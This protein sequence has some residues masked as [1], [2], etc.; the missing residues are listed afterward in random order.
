MAQISEKGK[1]RTASATTASGKI[2]VLTIGINDYDAISGFSP[3]TVCANNA[4]AIKNCFTDVFQLGADR[5]ALT[6]LVSNGVLSPSRGEIIKA[7]RKIAMNAQSADRI[8]VYFAGHGLRINDELYLAPQ[9]AY[10]ENDP[11]AHIAFAD[12]C[13]ILENSASK[14][15]LIILDVCLSGPELIGT[16]LLPPKVST[17]YLV[18][19][20]ALLKEVNVFLSS[21]GVDLAN[22]ESPDPKHNIFAYHLI[23]ALKGTAKALNDQ[24]LLTV[25]T[26][27]E[28][29]EAAIGEEVGSSSL[30]RTPSR[31][32][33]PKGMLTIG[34]FSMPLLN[35]AAFQLSEAPLLDVSF[36]DVEKIHVDRILTSL[37]SWSQYS[38]EQIVYSVNKNIGTALS[39]RLGTL[40]AE[41]TEGFGLAEGGVGESVNGII[42]ADGLYCMEYASNEK[43]TGTMTHTV[44]LGPSWFSRPLQMKKLLELFNVRPNTFVFRLSSP[45]KPQEIVPGL[46]SSGWTID[47]KLTE[48]VIASRDKYQ[49]VATP[50]TL[51]FY[52][53]R[54]EDIFGG[55]MAGKSYPTARAVIEILL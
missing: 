37:R 39:A 29:L 19:Q 35:R 13:Q 42:F 11:S 41:L 9:D 32:N 28:Y 25:D 12:L 43:K 51:N 4:A 44:S 7:A 40:I 20:L 47:S 52:G 31:G 27:F 34:D 14:Q 15:S 54:P 17:N 23:K 18:E 55:A 24:K 8:F 22:A 46:R 33:L 16:D 36:S 5:D 21:P 38:V 26:L 30:L 45:I 49:I 6:G 2:H 50:T 3:L 48:K 1:R 53:F 10:S